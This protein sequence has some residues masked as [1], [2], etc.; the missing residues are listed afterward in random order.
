MPPYLVKTHF[1]AED[2]N[3][4]LPV[5]P[6]ISQDRPW[7]RGALGP[8]LL[9]GHL[10]GK[11]KRPKQAVWAPSALCDCSAPAGFL[12]CQASLEQA[13]RASAERQM[14]GIQSDRGSLQII[15]LS[16]V[17]TCLEAG[18]RPLPWLHSLMHIKN[19]FGT[20]F[21][22]CSCSLNFSPLLYKS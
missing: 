11:S 12:R 6:T 18:Q 14:T 13:R 2:G 20:P 10:P 5:L 8:L 15:S 17:G 21:P 3:G 19:I 16:G 9:L 22:C 7:G 1:I 4:A